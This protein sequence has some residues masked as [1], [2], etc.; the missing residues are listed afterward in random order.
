[1]R[2][3]LLDFECLTP[4]ESELLCSDA[5]RAQQSVGIGVVKPRTDYTNQDLWSIRPHVADPAISD[6]TYSLLNRTD[7]ILTVCFAVSTGMMKSQL[8]ISLLSLDNLVKVHFL[9]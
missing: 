5:N 7:K 9:L 8:R 2:C 1:M 6:P 4:I 3:L